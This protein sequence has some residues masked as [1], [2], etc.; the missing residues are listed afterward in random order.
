MAQTCLGFNGG[1][2][3]ANLPLFQ[4][5]RWFGW[6]FFSIGVDIFISLTF[7]EDEHAPANGQIF[8]KWRFSDRGG[9]LPG[10]CSSGLIRKMTQGGSSC[11]DEFTAFEVCDHP[12]TT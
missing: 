3:P 6:P 1:F 7:K 9:R 4:G 11:F 5:L 10:L 12:V 2:G 8:D